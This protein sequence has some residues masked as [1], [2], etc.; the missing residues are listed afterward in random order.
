MG[1]LLV[2]SEKTKK[3]IIDYNVFSKFVKVVPC[4]KVKKGLKNILSGKRIM[5]KIV[6]HFQSS[7]TMKSARA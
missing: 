5:E 1:L 7:G 2:L 4:G 6:N 3:C